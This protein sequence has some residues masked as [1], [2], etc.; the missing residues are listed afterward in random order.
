MP[1]TEGEIE[2]IASDLKKIAI[3]VIWIQWDWLPSERS[4]ISISNK[5]S[6]MLHINKKTSITEDNLTNPVVT[7]QDSFPNYGELREVEIQSY[8]HNTIIIYENLNSA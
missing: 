6:Y 7:N 4:P 1:C 8:K 2:R 3:H 5:V